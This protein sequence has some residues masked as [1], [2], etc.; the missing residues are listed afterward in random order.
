VG[1]KLRRPKGK[2]MIGKFAGF[3]NRGTGNMASFVNENVLSKTNFLKD[4]NLIVLPG[5]EG[6]MKE[7]T[8]NIVWCHVP[9]YRM[10]WSL[11]KFFVHPDFLSITSMFL[12]QSEFHKKNLSENFAIDE[13]RFYIVNNQFDPIEFKEKPKDKINLMYISQASRGLDILLKCFNKI[14]DK[15]VTLTIHCCECEDCMTPSEISYEAKVIFDQDERIIK[16][17]DSTKEVLLDTL[18]KSHIYAY[19]CTF[20]E[21]ACIGVM[22]A[23]SAGVKVVT[24]DAGAL[25]ETTNGFAKIIKNYPVTFQD[26]EKR[27]KEMVKI[28]TK[29]IKKAIKEIR[30]NKF[31]PKPQIE[32]I[33]NRFSRDNCIRQWMELDKIIGDMQ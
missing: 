28:F 33:N 16:N 4:C 11:E 1:N 17:G 21:T 20:E 12:V 29:E 26:I 31:D 22:E 7:Y 9:A 10:P 2:K 25:P 5:L 13:D 32:Y 30:K 3:G 23:M 8:K 18:Q 19:P 27:E 15:D 24:T 6:N 14:K